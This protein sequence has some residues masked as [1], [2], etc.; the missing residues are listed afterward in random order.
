[1]NDMSNDVRSQTMA[2]I[3]GSLPAGSNPQVPALI[4]AWLGALD[5]DDLSGTAPASLA[6]AHIV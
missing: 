4:Q 3:N 5:Q 2:L 6:P 1:M